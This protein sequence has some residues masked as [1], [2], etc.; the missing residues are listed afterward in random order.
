[1]KMIRFG[2]LAVVAGI[3]LLAASC[4]GTP[5]PSVLA[6]TA[7][8]PVG[9]TDQLVWVGHG[10]SF[11]YADGQWIRTPESDYEFLVRQNRFADRW[12]S[13]KVQNRTHPDYDG[14]AG[15]ADQQHAFLIQY[16]PYAGGRVPITLQSTYGDGDGFTDPEF[17]EA[18]LEFEATDVS[19]F[20]P[21]NRFR[22]TQR[23]LY[24]QGRL[25]ETVELFKLED[26]GTE[27]PF[28]RIEERARMF[29]MQ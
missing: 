24:E 11:I 29:R 17:R 10:E 14:S 27:T 5:D 25:E 12:E 22:I 2:L 9:S 26:D 13:L 16:G 15:A 18:V 23:Y 8:T 7:A 6:G 28:V 4:A 3:V 20:A 1:M 19:R 21:Y